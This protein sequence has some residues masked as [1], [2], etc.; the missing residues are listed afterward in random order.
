MGTIAEKPQDLEKPNVFEFL[1]YRDFLEKFYFYKKQQ[2]PCSMDV[3]SSEES[4]HK[5]SLSLSQKAKYS[6]VGIVAGALPDSD[7]IVPFTASTPLRRF[8][9]ASLACSRR[10]RCSPC[11]GTTICGFTTSCIF[12]RS[13]RFAW[14]DTW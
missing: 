5:E 13:G 4:A 10:W 7:T 9:S 2:N 8:A 3:A 14:P 6:L 11:I 12:S 1:N